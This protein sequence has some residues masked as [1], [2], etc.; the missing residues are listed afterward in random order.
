[1]NEIA[2]GGAT[3]VRRALQ[4]FDQDADAD[5]EWVGCRTK[6]LMGPSSEECCRRPGTS[7][8]AHN[9]SVLAQILSK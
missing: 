4:G 9:P 7:G 3:T 6:R 5:K 8:G 1:M 2:R